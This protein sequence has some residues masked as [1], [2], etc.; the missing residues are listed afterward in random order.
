MTTVSYEQALRVVEGEWPEDGWKQVWI[1]HNAWGG[2]SFKLFHHPEQKLEHTSRT[3]YPDRVAVV[4]T[5]T[6]EE[7][8]QAIRDWLERLKHF[9][10]WVAEEP[11]REPKDS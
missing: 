11:P 4:G 2:T 8:N 7:F 3:L 6:P 9:E 1:Y 10:E 5:S